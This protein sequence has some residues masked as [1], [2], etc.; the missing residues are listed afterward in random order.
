MAEIVQHFG[1][2]LDLET[3]GP[4]AEVKSV[5]R[6]LP[7]GAEFMVRAV[8]G[9]AL[10]DVAVPRATTYFKTSTKTQEG[11]LKTTKPPAK[12]AAPDQQTD[13]SHDSDIT[14]NRD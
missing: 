14:T 1:V 7:F 2:V 12:G 4:P 10:E 13:T 6:A 9:A 11:T 8:A 3:L 5:G